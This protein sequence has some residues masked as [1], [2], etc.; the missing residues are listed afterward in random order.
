MRDDPIG[1]SGSAVC[2]GC[3]VKVDFF[4]T[5]LTDSFF[6]QVAVAAVNVLRRL[7]VEVDVPA[8][9]TCCGQPA[10]NTGLFDEARAVA[11]HMLDVFER[12]PVV[13]T[14][15]GSCCA[16]VRHYYPMLFAD[17]P[18]DLARA[19]ALGAKLFELVEFLEKVLRVDW[20]PWRL[21]YPTTATYHYSCH[22]RGL[23]MTD[24]VPRLLSKI[25]GLKLMPLEKFD[26]CCGFGGTF[27]VK[28]AHISGAI[29]NDKADCVERSGADV[30]VVN[31]GGC[32][33]NIAGVLHRRGSVVRVMH[34][35]QIL[36]AAMTA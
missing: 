1:W 21:R 22:L 14:P 33:L 20:G 31:D 27:A 16:M 28:Y 6:P 30:L 25:D 4:T 23:G 35:A 13:V 32:S 11:S 24:E 12:S 2:W 18:S 36:D 26:Q 10:F 17:S 34:T 7:G 5:C 8:D 19:R 3:I 15:S 29:A 9:Q